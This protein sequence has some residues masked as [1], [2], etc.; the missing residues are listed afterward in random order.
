MFDYVSDQNPAG[1]R[2]IGVIVPSLGNVVFIDLLNGIYDVLEAAGYKVLLA[3]S[4]YSRRE[5]EKMIRTLLN[6]GAEAV[7][8]TGDD[9]TSAAKKLLKD[10][11]VPVV[12][13]MELVEEPLD[14]NVGF[15]HKNAGYDVTRA[16]LAEGYSYIG[17][18][19]ART[20]SRV[21]QRMLGY[22]LALE[23][24]DKFWKT[25]IATTDEN[26]SV[27]IGARLFKQLMAST[28]GVVDAVFCANDDLALGALFESQR[29]GIRVPDDLAICGFNDTELASQ[30]N[31]SLTSVYVGRY[32]M[33][34]K[35]AE[36]LVKS[37]RGE[38]IDQKQ[39]D[40]GY[41]IR[42]RASTS[43]DYLEDIESLD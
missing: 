27:A 14:M 11:A 10:S 24:Q 5:E 20:D 9:Q 3:N 19:S 2:I 28:N 36:L 31:P 33:G 42:R 8:I 13:I 15:S 7:I 40:V 43:R 1:T 26:S 22:K 21:Q 12:Q 29:M 38:P 18:I 39:M 6:Q 25:F 41:E 16:L 32:E 17:F 34:V 37:L 23:E 35:A 4:H 30:V